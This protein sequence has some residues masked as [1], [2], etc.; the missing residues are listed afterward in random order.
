MMEHYVTL[1][2]NVF[3]PQ[4]F[5]LYLSLNRHAKDFT[6]WVLCLDNECFDTLR[7]LNL[8]NIKPL[9]ISDFET[10]E[11]LAVKQTRTRVEYCWTLTPFT[12][13]FVFNSDSSVRQV[14][15]LDADLFFLKSPE[16]I[17]EHFSNSNSSV[18][19]T[20]HAYHPNEDQTNDSGPY[21]VQFITIK[22]NLSGIEVQKYW[23]QC[24]LEW[25]YARFENGKFGDQRYLDD[26]PTRFKGLVYVLQHEEMAQAPWNA[27]RFPYSDAVFYHFQ[28]LR[29]IN[30]HTLIVRK[31]NIPRPHYKHIYIP[32]FETLA[33]SKD[34]L[35]EIG[36]A[37]K[38]QVNSKL[39]QRLFKYLFM[40]IAIIRRAFIN[41]FETER[42]KF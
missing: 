18:L 27:A 21:C 15:Y 37:I 32:Y 38:T 11:L 35:F 10:E 29:L 4:G 25:C 9:N 23:K 6:L 42:V 13:E 7:K 12:F 22:N 19:I 41:F 8:C 20:K 31:W 3:L 39:W 40:R 16:I 5:T 17:F 36:F 14:T 2:D 28:G 34:K 1:F 26:W 33:I 24:C 30:S